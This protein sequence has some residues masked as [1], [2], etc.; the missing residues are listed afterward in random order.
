M[1]FKAGN[2]TVRRENEWIEWRKPAWSI[3][4][5]SKVPIFEFLEFQN[6]GWINF[7][8][9]EKIQLKSDYKRFTSILR[10]PTDTKGREGKIISCKWK[11]KENKGVIIYMPDKIEFKTK[12][13]KKNHRKS[14]CNN[15]IN[16]SRR[17]DS[18]KIYMCPA[19]E[20]LKLLTNTNRYERRNRKQHN[21]VRELQ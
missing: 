6:S 5:P 2:Y 15:G 13:V 7:F 10:K 21:N 16:S 20:P 17:Y 8:K 19:S 3:G 12:T 14:L 11:P 9:K 4:I 1:R 18:C